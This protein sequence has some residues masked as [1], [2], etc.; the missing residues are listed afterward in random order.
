MLFFY[1]QLQIT[2]SNLV[3]V[4]VPVPFRSTGWED[5]IAEPFLLNVYESFHSTQNRLGSVETPC[6]IPFQVLAFRGA[7]REPPRLC[8]RGLPSTAISRRSR[9]PATSFHM[10]D[11]FIVS[12]SV[13]E[14]KTRKI[15]LLTYE[16]IDIFSMLFFVDIITIDSFLM[17]SH[18]NS[19]AFSKH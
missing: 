7:V 3:L 4:R 6:S 8:L 10:V 9:S 15:I 1:R 16:F 14:Y 18:V 5:L 13:L 12:N 17:V 2:H 19:H 11:H